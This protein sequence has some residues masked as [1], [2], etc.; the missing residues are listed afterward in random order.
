MVNVIRKDERP[1]VMY[2]VF[3]LRKGGRPS[4]SD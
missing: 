2:T 3:R 1:S 4:G